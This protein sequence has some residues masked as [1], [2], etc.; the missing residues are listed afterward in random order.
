MDSN[1]GIALSKLCLSGVVDV[2]RKIGIRR[3]L[4]A[5]SRPS[6]RE[7]FA[8]SN[9]LTGMSFE[10]DIWNEKSAY[11]LENV[12]HIWILQLLAD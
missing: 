8:L 6:S 2:D 9:W 12:K 11:S 4:L 3:T 5:L 10:D 7:L 1:S